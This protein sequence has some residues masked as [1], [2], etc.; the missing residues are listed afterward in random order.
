MQELIVF[1]QGKVVIA[2]CNSPNSNVARQLPGYLEMSEKDR[3]QL[4]GAIKSGDVIM[5]FIEHKREIVNGKF[6]I[7]KSPM[8]GDLLVKDPNG[9]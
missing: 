5:Y 9:E 8:F 2:N 6:S 3:K 7:M 4:D 1:Q